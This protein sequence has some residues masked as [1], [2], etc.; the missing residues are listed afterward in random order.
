MASESPILLLSDQPNSTLAADLGIL[1]PGRLEKLDFTRDPHGSS[2]LSGY[3]HVI[4]AVHDGSH[5]ERLDYAAV[6]AYAREGGKV[7]SCLY[8]YARHRGLHFSKTH[9]GNRMRPALRIEVENEITRGFACGDEVCWFGTVSSAPDCLYSNQMYQ[10]QIL[11]V[12]ESA[13]VSVLATS[14]VNGGAVLIEER[15]DAGRIL[16]LDLASPGRPFHNSPGSTNKYLFPGNFIGGSVRY[17]KHYP[18]RLSYD[19]FVDAMHDLAARF[20][21]LRLRA[22]GSC[23]DGRRMWT[24]RLGDEANPTFYFGAAVHGWEWENAF[25]LLRLAEVLCEQPEI[26]GL[27]TRELH[28]CIMPIQNPAGYDAFT[29]QNARGVDLNRNFDLGWEELA[30]PQDVAVPWDYNYKGTR[31]ASEPETRI[32]QG[33]IDH[34]EPVCLVD[35]HTADY[36]MLLPHRGDD[37]LVDAIHDEIK[38]RLKDRYLTQ[39]PYNGPYQQVNME[40]RTERRRSPYLICYAAEKGTPAAFLIEMSGNRDDTHALVMNTDT[41]VEICLAAAAGL[42]HSQTP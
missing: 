26:E 24:F 30:V 1:Y 37:R 34:T 38:S 12:R 39:R 5:A 36:I 14:T 22:E 32:I 18:K 13:E 41:V 19:E 15:T 40:N 35:F 23:S 33:I 27:D 11:N 31:P 4:T 8:E 28:F 42:I 9:V 16:A 29:R 7:I 6:D 21:A 25:G 17:G 20:P 10:R 3:G 2:V